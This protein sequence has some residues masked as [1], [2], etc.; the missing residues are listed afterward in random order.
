VNL[1]LRRYHNGY[2]IG[3]TGLGRALLTLAILVV[4]ASVLYIAIMLVHRSDEEYRVKCEA[5][6]GHVTRISDHDMCVDDEYR[7]IL[8]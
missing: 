5:H 3:L 2:A 4:A 8:V 6:G 7:I 1:A